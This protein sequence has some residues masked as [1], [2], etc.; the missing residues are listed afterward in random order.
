MR[1]TLQAVWNTSRICSFPSV[2][3]VTTITAHKVLFVLRHYHN[4]E[5][6]KA[7]SQY[8]KGLDCLSQNEINAITSSLE[9]MTTAKP[10]GAEEWLELTRVTQAKEGW[11]AS[12]QKRGIMT[13]MM[14]ERRVGEEEWELGRR[15]MSVLG[16]GALMDPNR[17]L[18]DVYMFVLQVSWSRSLCA[19]TGPRQNAFIRASRG[20]P[21]EHAV[22][23]HR[24]T[25]HCWAHSPPRKAQEESN[26]HT[27]RASPAGLGSGQTPK[28]QHCPKKG[29]LSQICFLWD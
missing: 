23:Q 20:S 8:V 13:G 26:S 7:R 28:A 4:N 2:I 19:L 6:G 18:E 11:E 24:E 10:S 27:S 21:W 14:T 22:C 29:K 3:L 12:H 16:E 25:P 5:W 17:R 9:I 15:R 1:K